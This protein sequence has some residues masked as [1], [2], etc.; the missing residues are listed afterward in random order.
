MNHPPTYERTVTIND[1]REIAPS[2]PPPHS[3]GWELI[4]SAAYDSLTPDMQRWLSAQL[5]H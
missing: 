5:G 3:I 4:S 2:D 1:W